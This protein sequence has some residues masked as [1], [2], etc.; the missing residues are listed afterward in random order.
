MIVASDLLTVG[1]LAILLTLL[2]Q[3]IKPGIRSEWIPTAAVILGI[4][5]AVAA[6][7]VTDL[8][9][10]QQIADAV[11]TGILAGFSSVG[12]YQVQARAPVVLLKSK[13]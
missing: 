4:I 13:E 6:S 3:L 12:L 2:V 10:K 8:T 1:G 5:I 9:S 11:L 7:W